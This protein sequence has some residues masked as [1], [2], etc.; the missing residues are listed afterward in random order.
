MGY[1]T[2]SALLAEVGRVCPQRAWGRPKP[3][4]GALGRDALQPQV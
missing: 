4:D 1:P 2:R 3:P